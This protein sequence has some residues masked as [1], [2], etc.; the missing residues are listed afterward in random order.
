[1]A[2]RFGF[3]FLIALRAL[4]AIAYIGGQLSMVEGL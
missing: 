1:M 3:R 4:G 2:D